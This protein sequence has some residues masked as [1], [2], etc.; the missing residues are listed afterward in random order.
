MEWFEWYT[1][2]VA[3]EMS[4]GIAQMVHIK[5]RSWYNLRWYHPILLCPSFSCQSFSYQF[6]HY[7]GSRL[8]RVKRCKRNS[9]FK[10]VLAA[11]ELL[12]IAVNYFDAKKSARNSWVL[13]VTELVVS[14][15]QC[16]WEGIDFT[17]DVVCVYRP[18]TERAHKV[19]VAHEHNIRTH[20]LTPVHGSTCGN[21]Q[22]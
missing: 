9:S 22:A 11:T 7:T 21:G 20:V 1:L 15:T 4:H 16:K 5:T 6:L 17:Y 14:E 8:Q 18:Y 19:D 12:N 13:V 3:C 10:W 2:T